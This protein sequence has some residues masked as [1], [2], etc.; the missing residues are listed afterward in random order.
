MNSEWDE[1]AKNWDVDPQVEKYAESAFSALT[2]KVDLTG[3]SVLDFG[4]G[5]GALT[6]RLSDKAKEVVAIDPSSEM[7]KFLEQK[8]LNNVSAISEYLNASLIEVNPLFKNKFDL[9]TASSVCSF[10]PDYEGTLKLL[11]CLLKPGGTFIQWDWLD[12]DET[13]A[14]GLPVNRVESALEANG[15]SNIQVITPFIMSSSKG[16]MPV[17]MG[18]GTRLT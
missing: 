10:L 17:L 7:I 11:Y 18:V 8:S 3:L 15:F 16:E 4:C 2:Q 14:F 13:T 5:T 9:I 6:K 1:Y 12:N